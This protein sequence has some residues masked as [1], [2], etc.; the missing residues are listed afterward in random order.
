MKVK[1]LGLRE[2][3]ALAALAISLILAFQFLDPS[4]SESTGVRTTN[5]RVTVAP[6]ATPSPTAT[7]RPSQPLPTPTSWL[8]SF[9]SGGFDHPPDQTTVDSLSL[10]VAK[11]PFV[12]YRDNQWQVT[13]AARVEVEDGRYEFRLRHSCD[14]RVLVDGNEVAA[15]G[16]GGSKT[17]RVVFDH[18]SGPVTLTIFANDV[19]GPFELAWV[20]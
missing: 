15:E 8:L 1:S 10:S 18:A 6:T 16:S 9:T 7:P 12:D 11:A 20:N 3:F 2:Y 17:L 14:V 4:A 19:D 13:A 5:I